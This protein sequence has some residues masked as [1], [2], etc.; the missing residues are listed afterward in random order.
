LIS[1]YLNSKFVGIGA[2]GQ[3]FIGIR[4]VVWRRMVWGRGRVIRGRCIGAMMRMMRGST[5]E[6]RG[7]G[8]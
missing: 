6:I 4:G 1:L 3:L 5:E 7:T 8:P 2:G